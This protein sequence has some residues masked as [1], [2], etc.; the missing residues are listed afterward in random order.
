MVQR[1]NPF[2]V[3]VVSLRRKHFWRCV[4][5]P[6]LRTILESGPSFSRD[7]RYSVR[8]EFGALYFSASEDLALVEVAARSGE[9]GEPA[10]S[11]EFE[12]SVGRLADL[13]R[14]EIRAR[15][16]VRL[17][18]LV[19]PRIARDAYSAPQAIARRVYEQGLDGLLAPSVHDPQ[20]QRR[21]WFNLVLYPANLIRPL[22][23]EVRV[24]QVGP[25]LR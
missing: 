22:L 3:P 14:Q 1:S 13:T 19:R 6:H 9:D 21:D 15:W 7:R 17:E 25:P 2:A 24:R 20:G 16:R 10:C 5:Q 4:P 8:G 12:V 18:D 11:V 23:R